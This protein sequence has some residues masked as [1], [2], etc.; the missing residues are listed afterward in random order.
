M[1]KKRKRFLQEFEKLPIHEK[2]VRLLAAFHWLFSRIAKP[3]THRRHR[4]NRQKEI[5]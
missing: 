4:R 1:S 3:P 2:E 5:S